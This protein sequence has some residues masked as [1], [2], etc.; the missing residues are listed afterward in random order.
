MDISHIAVSSNTIELLR[1]I[2]QYFPQLVARAFYPSNL[3]LANLDHYKI[4]P[5]HRELYCTAVLRSVNHD[6]HYAVSQRLLLCGR[7]CKL[8]NIPGKYLGASE[9]KLFI[10]VLA[11]V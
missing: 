4:R 2:T 1:T 9:A 3:G 7:G 6:F 11:I 8:L 10:E 5:N